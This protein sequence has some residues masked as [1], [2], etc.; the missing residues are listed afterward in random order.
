M[1]SASQVQVLDKSVCISFYAN[2]LRKDMYSSLLS[3]A[4]DKIVEQTA[5]FNLV[6]ECPGYDPKLYQMVRFSLHIY[7][8]LLVGFRIC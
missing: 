6:K 4:M 7:T 2:A 3:P 1:D 8:T 5:L